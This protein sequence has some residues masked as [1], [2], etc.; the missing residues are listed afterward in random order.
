MK[1]T[2]PWGWMGQNDSTC[3][4]W[5]M[6][7]FSEGCAESVYW[8]PSE[9]KNLSSKNWIHEKT[10]SFNALNTARCLLSR[11]TS[12]R[13]IISGGKISLSGLR[14][15]WIFEDYKHHIQQTTER[16]KHRSHTSHVWPSAVI[17]H[18]R[19][20]PLWTALLRGTAP[21]QA[22]TKSTST[23]RIQLED[24]EYK[25]SLHGTQEDICAV[26]LASLFAMS[27]FIINHR[28]LI[29]E[30]QRRFRTRCRWRASAQAADIF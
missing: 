15:V 20:I 23:S 14:L 22:T 7:I 25:E 13:S 11:I 5:L 4:K 2:S 3:L 28:S 6:I 24:K 26:L 30:I 9:E 10:E 12:V 27:R 21:L 17:S 18:S 19:I 29:I 1:P 8:D 16:Y